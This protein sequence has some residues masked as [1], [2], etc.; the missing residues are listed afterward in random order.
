VR[1]GD[2]EIVVT[3]TVEAIAP[4]GHTCPGNDEVPFIVDLGE[5][6][7]DRELVDGACL[8]GGE[9]A[10]TSFCAQGGTRW[11]P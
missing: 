6:V 10:S 3:F 9:A 4:G 8:S 1:L 2:T 7:G 5:A 11:T